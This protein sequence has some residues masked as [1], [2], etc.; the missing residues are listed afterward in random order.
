[1]KKINKV[2]IERIDDTIKQRYN[3]RYMEFGIDARTLGWGCKEDQYTRFKAAVTSVDFTEKSVLDIGCGFADFYEFL[4][5]HSIKVKKYK[6]IDINEHLIEVAKKRFP[7]NMYEV[8]NILLHNYNSEQADIV[9]LFGLLNFKLKN[10]NNMT[11]TKK[12][13]TATLKIT[14]EKLI[15]DFLSTHLTKTYPKEDAVYYHN[16]KDVLDICFKLSNNVVL[17]HNYPSI[18]QKEFLIVITKEHEIPKK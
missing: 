8:R 10:V 5:Q 7:E 14:K 3:K 6:G 2:E 17:V 4:L 1:M 13:I 18:P 11:Y 9:T 16:P 12:M 15:V